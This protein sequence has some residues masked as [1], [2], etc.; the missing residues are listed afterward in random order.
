MSSSM[1]D[2]ESQLSALLGRDIKEAIRDGTFGGS[3]AETNTTTEEEK[4]DMS[5]YGVSKRQQDIDQAMGEA[6]YQMA[7]KSKEEGNDPFSD[8]MA[9][10]KRMMEN[11]KQRSEEIS[12]I[13]K[14]EQAILSELCSFFESSSN[15]DKTKDDKIKEVIRAREIIEELQMNVNFP[16]LAYG[17]TFLA[18]S[19]S[20]SIEMMQLLLE[21]GENEMMCEC[22]IDVLMEIED[23]NELTEEEKKMKKLLLDKGAKTAEQRLTEMAEQVK[24][25]RFGGDSDDD[26][27][28]D[29]DN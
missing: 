1:I 19:V 12:K 8:P 27:S 22:P 20:H 16:A 5:A 17:E 11:V 26:G 21:K 9:P 2:L 29:D 7:M 10:A 4:V 14:D 6:M 28:E 13:S 18:A 23:D 15:R 25:S 24:K 3:H